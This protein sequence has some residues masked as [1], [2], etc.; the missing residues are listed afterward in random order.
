MPASGRRLTRLT[1]RI[2]LTLGPNIQNPEP[3]RQSA[4]SIPN[5]SRA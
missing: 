3:A 2:D 1:Q 5:G 4:Q